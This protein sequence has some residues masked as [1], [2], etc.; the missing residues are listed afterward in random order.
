MNCK[1]KLWVWEAEGL[2]RGVKPPAATG[3]PQG[4]RQWQSC[5]GRWPAWQWGS[6]HT[7]EPVLQ[8][9]CSSPYS[10]SHRLGKRHPISL[11]RPWASI[12]PS[13]GSLGHFS[14]AMAFFW[15]AG[16]ADILLSPTAWDANYYRDSHMPLS[17]LAHILGRLY[18]ALSAHPHPSLNHITLA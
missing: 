17:R 11:L 6:G 14:D 8:C 10:K 16:N 3:E 7:A 15:S 5:Q 4:C 13:F 9:L 18:M 1:A 2:P 12:L